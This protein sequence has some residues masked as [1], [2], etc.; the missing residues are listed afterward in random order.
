MRGKFITFE[1]PE[2]AGKSTQVRRLADWLAARGIQTVCL[3]EPGGTLL[4][5]EIR[6]VLQYNQA[7]EAPCGRAELLLFAA[8]RSQLVETVIRP[9][10]AE[11]CWVLCDRFMDSTTAY[12]GGGRGLPLDEIKTLH[13]LT[14]NGLLPDLTLLLD[15]DVQ[16]GFQRVAG[17]GAAADRFEQEAVA[18]HERVR[19]AYLQLAAEEPT[20]FRIL[21]A[22]DDPDTIARRIQGAVEH[23]L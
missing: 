19:H 20:R 11:G 16:T 1:G 8:S 13:R 23:V 6:R 18:F 3:R 14:L 7:G 5:E 15:L 21:R 10:L 12:Q 2:G 4:G 22:E 9:R 17:R